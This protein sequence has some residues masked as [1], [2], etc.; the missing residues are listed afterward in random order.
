MKKD[1]EETDSKKKEDASGD[2][3]K[4]DTNSNSKK[5]KHCPGHELYKKI[6]VN[7]PSYDKKLVQKAVY[8]AVKHHGSQKRA[9]GDPYYQHPISVA[10]ILA[11]LNM[12]ITTI[13]TAILHDTV[14]DTDITLEDIK[15]EFGKDV[16]MLVSGVTKLTKMELPSESER[17]AENFRKLLLAISE[18]IRV[19]LVKLADRLHNMRTLQYIKKPEKRHRIAV[20]TMEIYAPL[21]ERIGMQNIKDELQDIAFKEINPEGYES[22]INRLKQLKETDE[23]IILK[24]SKKLEKILQE[25]KLSPIVSGR[26]KKPY[27]IWRKMHKKNATF[28]Q[29]TDIIAFR[30]ILSDIGECYQ[31]LGLIHSSFNAVPEYF[32]DYIST[33]K[34]NGYSSLHTVVIGP[35]NKRIEIQIRTEDMHE[36]SEVGVAAHW[37]YK[38]GLEYSFDGK[39]YKWIR[40]LLHIVSQEQGSAEFMEDTKLEMY[41]DQVFCFTPRGD[42]IALPVGATAVDFAFAVHSEIG[43]T[44]VGTKINNRIMPLR[45][46]L[47]NG[48]QIEV[49]QSNSQTPSKSWES[50]VITGKARSEIRRFF[51]N[52]KESEYINLGRTILEK[53]LM[54]EKISL[55]DKL[56]ENNLDKFNKNKVNDVYKALGEGVLT[57]KEVC[58]LL[59]PDLNQQ[60]KKSSIFSIFKNKKETIADSSVRIPI[61]GVSQGTAIHYASCCH[62]LP[63]ENIIGIIN[64]GK[65]ITIHT[66]GC[67]ELEHFLDTPERWVNV[68]WEEKDKDS[69]FVVRIRAVLANKKGALADIASALTKEET[70]ITNFRII[71]RANDF[72]EV[73]LDIEVLN[74]AHFRKV[75]K[76]LSSLKVVHT[77][78]RYK[79]GEDTQNG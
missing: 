37:S 76:A 44:C 38:Q 8:F 65:G 67:N 19:L 7:N 39:Q 2:A 28:E 52:E 20:E 21:A 15:T 77:I 41:H 10:E 51:K 68:F 63:G 46:K 6:E 55:D 23:K 69:F 30:V 27:S 78:Q 50:F 16:S 74:I 18:D 25:S 11:D 31:A 5:E 14:E 35:E 75:M 66:S 62:P 79:E 17:Q 29:L 40:E 71:N 59:F 53:S 12:D 70:N 47:Q 64:S 24:I 42:L 1:N 60:K 54:Q 48:D 57:K 33:P 56:I 45:T 36:V 43:K 9:S 73:I 3:K 34:V 22:V 32:K 26:E 4:P 72:Y 13:V 58:E 49:L 61:S